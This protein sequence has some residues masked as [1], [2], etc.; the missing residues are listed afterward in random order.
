MLLSFME[1][2]EGAHSVQNRTDGRVRLLM[3]S[4]KRKPAVAVYPD[5]DKLA[6]WRIEG[7]EI[8]VR[9]SAAVDYWDGEN[10]DPC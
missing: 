9:R 4:T 7:D 6:L 5:S 3:L 8:V 10:A 2:P 1:G